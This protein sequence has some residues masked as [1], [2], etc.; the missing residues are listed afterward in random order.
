MTWIE[1]QIRELAFGYA[2]RL[3]TRV[4]DRKSEMERDDKSHHLI[5]QV[6]GIPEAEGTLI[7]I[8]QNKGRF[9]YRYAGAFL[10]ASTLRCFQHKFPDAETKVRIPNPRHRRPKTFEID[11]LVGKEAFEIKWRDAT[12]DGDHVTKEHIRAKT[13][14]EA[15]Y[16]P[17][18]IMFYYPNRARAL[19]I[20]D[21]LKTVYAGLG[22][23]YYAGDAAWTYVRTKTS[24]DLKAILTRIADEKAKRQTIGVSES[25]SHEEA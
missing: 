12:T 2:D 15:G 7:D 11:C 21:T 25:V 6:L 8:Y 17:I 24:V 14:Q 22:G 16:T 23:E 13:I 9:L 20:Q 5:Y 3:E 10:E 18:R 19:K 1:R 4:A